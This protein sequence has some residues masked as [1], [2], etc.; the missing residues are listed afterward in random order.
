MWEKSEN[1][2]SL[3]PIL[4]ELYKKNYRG[5]QI[6]PPLSR[7]RVKDNIN[8]IFFLN[9][10]FNGTFVNQASNMVLEKHSY[11]YLW[12]VKL[13]LRSK[14]LLSSYLNRTK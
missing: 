13:F 10:D 8:L 14:Y 7:H 5:G 4:F 11:S 6:D 3:R 1:F 2:N 9:N 12:K